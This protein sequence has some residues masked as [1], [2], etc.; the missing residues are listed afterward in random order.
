MRLVKRLIEVALLLFVISLFMKNK[1]IVMNINYFGLS[2]PI[3]VQFWEL[4]SFCI[5]LGV[6]I[7]ALGDFITQ[8]KW[9]KE[10]RRMMKTDREHQSVVSGLNDKI[11]SLETE[12]QRLKNEL[13]QKEQDRARL[14]QREDAPAAEESEEKPVHS[15]DAAQS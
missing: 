11:Q 8:L 14:R 5:A 1:D 13:E 15:T 2:E 10:R 4:V 3:T 12:N 9:I 7:A 6:I